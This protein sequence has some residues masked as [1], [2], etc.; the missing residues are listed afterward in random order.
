MLFIYWRNKTKSI[1]L[2]LGPLQRCSLNVIMTTKYYLKPKSSKLD[3]NI[4]QRQNK[5]RFR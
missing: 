3:N 5:L 2:Q 1:A 4:D